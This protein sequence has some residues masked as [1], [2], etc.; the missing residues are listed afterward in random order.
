MSRILAVPLAAL[1]VTACENTPVEAPR[2]PPAAPKPAV[3]PTVMPPVAPKPPEPPADTLALS[4]SDP[5]GVDHLARAERLRGEGDSSGALIEARKA[6]ADDAEDTDALTLVAEL[7]RASGQKSLAAQAYERLARLDPED[8]VSLIQAARM[9]LGA[10]V[11]GAAEALAKAAIS[12]DDANVE[13]W[14]ALGR[15]QLSQGNLASAIRSLEQ[16]RTLAPSHGWVLNNLGFAYLRANQN[17]EALEVLERSA[18]LLPEA[19]V[20]QNNLGVA[21]ERTGDLEGAKEAYARST[22]LAPRYVKAQ[23][24]GQRMAMARTDADGGVQS[25]HQPTDDDGEE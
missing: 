20:V 6:L 9:R 11:P 17:G 14:Q 18:E 23:V 7:G 24:N 22:L 19:A 13:A 15:A 12:R 21:R 2:S 25:P 5:P 10:G 8:A 3:T 16:A 4:H 1:L